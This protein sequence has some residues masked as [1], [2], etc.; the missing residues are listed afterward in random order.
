MPAVPLEELRATATALGFRERQLEQT[1]QLVGL[2]GALQEHP[3]LR[4]S[5]AL[6]GGTALNLFVW[7]APRLSVDIDLN[8]MAADETLAAM[9]AARPR[10]EEAVREIC[11]RRDL[12][13]RSVPRAHAGG[14][15]ALR[16]ASAFGSNAVV[17][18]DLNF[19]FRI[20][21]WP[22]VKRDSHPLG[23]WQV[24]DFPLM[25]LHELAAGKLVALL[26]RDKARDLFDARSI[27]AMHDLDTDCLRTAF[28]AYGAMVRRD[29][30]TVSVDD[31]RLRTR[32]VRNH[33]LPLLP[34]REIEASD[35]PD[36][37]GQRLVSDCREGLSRVLP[38]R[39]NEMAFLDRLLDH[40][41]VEPSLL[42]DDAD[43]QLKLISHPLL[44]WK[45]LNVRR[46]NEQ[47][48]E[49]QRR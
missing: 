43:L 9:Q 29:W 4:D 36:S 11:R 34:D 8:Y 18:F 40:G 15:W 27:W 42:T 13:V 10:V 24:S 12:V 6:K 20:S 21:L 23:P 47:R 49:N 30:R 17:A 1:V 28:V 41:R 39:D 31:V 14:K 3:F 46:H 19:M 26:G 16:F 45:A 2:L 25:D 38:F 35:D 44:N 5:L 37:Y 33:L 48:A 32:D 7:D 22:V